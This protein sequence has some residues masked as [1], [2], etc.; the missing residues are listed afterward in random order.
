MVLFSDRIWTSG[1]IIIQ[2][3][4]NSRFWFWSEVQKS[5]PR[6]KGHFEWNH[7]RNYKS[8]FLTF[9]LLS[10]FLPW[11]ECKLRGRFYLL[12]RWILLRLSALLWHS[13]WIRPR[14]IRLLY[15]SLA[16]EIHFRQHF[17]R[18]AKFRPS[19]FLPKAGSS[20][21]HRDH[22]RWMCSTSAIATRPLQPHDNIFASNLY[23]LVAS[24][25]APHI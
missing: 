14:D 8:S 23:L 2:F 3:D 19:E 21:Y 22:G 1:I 16:F 24:D 13:W 15:D 12:V 6:G 4:I 20:R 25:Q 11:W 5:T 18:W 17:A 9:V 10:S 7:V